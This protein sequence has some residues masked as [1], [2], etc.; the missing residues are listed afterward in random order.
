MVTK[1]PFLGDIPGLGWL[2]KT[3]S[4]TKT[5]TN[6][7]ILLTP[8]IVKDNADLAA[9]TDSQRVKIRRCRQ[10]G[11]SGG[12]AEGDWRKMSPTQLPEELESTARRLGIACQ[13]EIG[14]DEVDPALLAGC[15]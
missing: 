4:K 7:M 3:K 10:K 5:K 6:L 11:R 14:G 2:F 1:V 12:C 9:I 13:P 15:R 8:R